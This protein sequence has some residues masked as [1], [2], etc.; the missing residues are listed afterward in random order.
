MKSASHPNRRLLMPILVGLLFPVATGLLA[1]GCEKDEPPPPLPQPK[2]EPAA[3]AEPL[4]LMPEED[5]GEEDAGDEKKP[6]GPYKPAMSLKNCCG[7][8]QQNSASA[9]EP[10]ATYMK[11]AAAACYAAVGAGQGQAAVLAAVRGALR[12][13]G[14][15]AACH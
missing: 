6:T 11:Q 10:T 9:P 14:M 4:A 5:A 13:A 1:S 2:E 12:G 3:S 7:A 8:L 15:P